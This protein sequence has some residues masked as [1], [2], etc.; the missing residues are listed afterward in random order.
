MKNKQ[1]HA[2]IVAC[3]AIPED[4]IVEELLIPDGQTKNRNGV[5]WVMDEESWSLIDKLFKANGVAIPIDIKHEEHKNINPK[6][7]L[8]AVGWVESMRYE[9]GR[10]VLGKIRWNE[11]GKKRI[12]GDQFRYLSPVIGIREDKRVAGLVSVGLVTAPAIPHMERVASMESVGPIVEETCMEELK[13]IRNALGAGDSEP[14]DA[15][16]KKIAEGK[17][18]LDAATAVANAAKTALALKD[19]A[20]ASEVGV[21]INSL[22]QAGDGAKAIADRLKLVENQLAERTAADLVA[23]YIA[24]NKINP[25]AKEDLAMCNEL[26]RTNPERFKKLMDERQPYVQPGRTQPPAGSTTANSAEKDEELIANR[27]KDRKCDYAT[28]LSELQ[29]EFKKPY[30]DQGL[31]NKAANQAAAAAHPKIFEI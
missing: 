31:S 21:A 5:E 26:A 24:A 18:K 15:L 28:A 14:V 29:H 4:G 12:R 6:D 20:S 10:G 1:V 23:P 2:N 27:M 30:L 13:L 16:V 22:R 7:V 19:D 3:S 9:K 25:N 11:E 8:G 17:T